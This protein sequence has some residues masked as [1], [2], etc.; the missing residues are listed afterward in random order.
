MSDQRNKI[1]NIK[2]RAGEEPISYYF[3]ETDGLDNIRAGE[4]RPDLPEGRLEAGQ[5]FRY[6][7]TAYSSPGRSICIMARKSTGELIAAACDANGVLMDHKKLPRSSTGE[8]GRERERVGRKRINT[9]NDVKTRE[10][11]RYINDMDY[12]REIAQLEYDAKR[13]EAALRG[14]GGE[15]ESK[16]DWLVLL[17]L[18]IFIFIIVRAIYK[19]L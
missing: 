15:S 7:D 18:L 11:V 9:L 12:H 4:R 16:W 6:L 5:E 8:G 2:L 10:R 14:R 19:S 17:V 13:K 3:V 1:S